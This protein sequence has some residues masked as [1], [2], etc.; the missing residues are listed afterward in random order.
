M[1]KEVLR[2]IYKNGNQMSAA[3]QTC[4]LDMNK[5]V[6]SI[7]WF[8]VLFFLLYIA[9]VNGSEP[10]AVKIAPYHKAEWAGNISN[11]DIGEASGIAVSSQ[12][13]DILWMINDSGNS[14]SIYAVHSN[15]RFMGEFSVK[16][17]PNTDWE[18]LAVFKYN[19]DHF[20]LIGDIGD[21]N[22]VRDFCSLY[23]VKEPKMDFF[24]PNENK[25]LTPAYELRFRYEDGPQ[26]CESVAVDIV[27]WRILLLS[28]R[29]KHPDLY[30][31]PLK[32]N[33]SE[34]V[35]TARQIATITK[36]PQPT[37]ADFNDKYGKYRSQPT[38]MD[39]S[40]DGNILIILTYKDAYFYQKKG[41]QTWADVFE[42]PPWRISL[43]HPNTGELQQ[44]E[45]ICISHRTGELMVTSEG[46]FAPIYKLKPV[47]G[48]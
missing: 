18:D 20:I 7:F 24:V 28:K 34:T 17:T 5:Q 26:D 27:N 29:K 13:D 44:R 43:P 10:Q 2:C 38:S 31:L 6:I 39:V 35:E 4:C 25:V 9:A 8:T 32:L 23:I 22:A 47:T 19:Y 46:R 45:A 11:P 36:I 3:R 41:R 30:S 1:Q 21:N 48:K 37:Q 15:G 16:N 40:H 33:A 12:N 42:K 14:P